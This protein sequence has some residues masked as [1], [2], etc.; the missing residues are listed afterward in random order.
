MITVKDIQ[1]ATDYPR[2]CK[3]DARATAGRRR[4]RHG[5][6]RRPRRR[7][8]GGRRGRVVVDTAH[9]HSKGVIDTRAQIKKH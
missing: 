5:P 3:D 8:G 4:R 2:A 1:K 9:G 7:A 6:R